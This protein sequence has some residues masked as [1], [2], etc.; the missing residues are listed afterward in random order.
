MPFSATSTTKDWDKVFSEVFRPVIEEAGLG[1]TC[2]RSENQ[3]GSFTK[4]IVQNLR[5]AFLVLADIT[6]FNP[7]VMWELGVRHSLSRR[8]IMVARADMIE[9][10]PSDIKNYGVIPYDTEITAFTTFRTQIKQILLKIEAEP[11]RSDNPVFDFLRIEELILT[12]NERKTTIRKLSGL[13]TEL[14]TNLKIADNIANGTYSVKPESI[15]LRRYFTSAILHLI[16]TNYVIAD[17]TYL[18]RLINTAILM[19]NVNRRLD[20]LMT[21]KIEIT[22]KSSLPKIV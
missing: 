21:E 16:N 14:F 2:Q 18:Q 6:D 15:T 11:E 7:N 5:S 19:E 20:Y 17:K 13:L 10:I 1:Y 8:T 12:Q 22:R 4:E 3:N 9:K